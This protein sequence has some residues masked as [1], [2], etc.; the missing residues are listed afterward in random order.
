MSIR[1]CNDSHCKLIEGHA[2][3]HNPFPNAAWAFFNKQD[4]NKIVKAGF[5]TPRGG[6][7]GAY[8]NHVLRNSKVIIPYER[9]SKVDLSKFENSY[10]IRLFPE[11]YFSSSGI[12]KAEFLS[13]NSAVSVG[14]NAFVL[15]RTHESFEAFP[16]LASWEIRYLEKDGA[17][18]DRR[19][20]NVL[21]KGHYVLRLPPKDRQRPARTEGAPQGIFAPE[22][23][24]EEINF[25]SKAL[26][27]WLIIICQDSP[28]TTSQANHLKAILEKA[29]VYNLE[30]W[31]SDGVTFRGFTACPLCQRLIKYK[32]L[33]EMVDFND[34]HGLLNASS[35]VDGATRST[36]VNLFHINPLSYVLL[37]HTPNSVAWGHANCNTKLG[38]RK[39][40]SLSKLI[41]SGKKVAVLNG[42]DYETFGWL[43]VDGSML[44][45]PNGAL[46]IK[47]VNDFSEV[48]I[49]ERNKDNVSI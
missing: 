30:K 10:V 2:G 26:L 23:A 5:A 13:K 49:E 22:Y 34:I 21:D 29:G 19:G 37:D 40:Y 45:S 8:Q 35:Q 17:R 15:Y 7:K 16:P 33:H 36:S 32:E 43:S 47:I 1:L 31:E 28:Y 6:L 4:S 27:S 14:K 9:I 44:R 42:S 11:Q 12:L 38:Q 39:C 25:L 48:E 46:W 18:V 24:N 20:S 41:E 3:E